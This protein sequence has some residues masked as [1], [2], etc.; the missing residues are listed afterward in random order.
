VP[1]KIVD[2]SDMKEFFSHAVITDFN[3]SKLEV[4]YDYDTDTEQIQTSH[5]MLLRELA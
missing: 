5:K 2:E 3:T 4:E 1:F